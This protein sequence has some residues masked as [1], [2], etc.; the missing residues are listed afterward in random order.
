MRRILEI[1]TNNKVEIDD[2]N[3]NLEPFTF[4]VKIHAAE[5]NINRNAIERLVNTYK[6]AHTSYSLLFMA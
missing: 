4:F 2:Q 5:K 6:P 1:Y 3:E